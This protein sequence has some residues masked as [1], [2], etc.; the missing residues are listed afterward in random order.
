[1]FRAKLLRTKMKTRCFVPADDVFVLLRIFKLNRLLHYRDKKKKNKNKCFLVNYTCEFFTGTFQVLY[2]SSYCN[3]FACMCFLRFETTGPFRG[4]STL[5]RNFELT[6]AFLIT[7]DTYRRNTDKQPETYLSQNYYLNAV[8]CEQSRLKVLYLY[9][10]LH[11][12]EKFSNIK[13]KILI[14]NVSNNRVHIT[15][16]GLNLPFSLK[17]GLVVPVWQEVDI[18]LHQ[19]SDPSQVRSTQSFSRSNRRLK[20]SHN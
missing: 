14:N 8:C 5:Y 20:W 16:M 6:V 4:K 11:I 17:D 9:I 3:S 19:W 2:Q 12:N 10:I 18:F 1:M 15:L 13:T 7:Q